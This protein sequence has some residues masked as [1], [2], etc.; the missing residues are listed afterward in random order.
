MDNK[1]KTLTIR[2]LEEIFGYWELSGIDEKGF[3]LQIPSYD[4]KVKG[5]SKLKDFMR[6]YGIEKCLWKTGEKTRF[7][8]PNNVKIVA[9]IP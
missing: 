3:Y 2:K 8:F 9:D 1:D 7:Y 6:E 5:N 4:L